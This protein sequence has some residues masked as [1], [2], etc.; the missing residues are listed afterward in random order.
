MSAGVKVG[1]FGMILRLFGE[2][3]PA[4]GPRWQPAVAMLA[5]PVHA[6]VVAPDVGEIEL[7]YEVSG[8]GR[9]LLMISGAYDPIFL[10]LGYHV[11][12]AEMT[13]EEKD[14]I[15]HRGQGIS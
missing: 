2:G 5:G 11:T 7:D 1:A 15:S 12:T 4:L 13:P 8:E 14:A 3:L 9:P 10:P 6:Q